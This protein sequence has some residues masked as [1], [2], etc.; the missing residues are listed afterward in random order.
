MGE[1][2]AVGV[3]ALLGVAVARAAHRAWR[4]GEGRSDTIATLRAIRW[5]HVLVPIPLLALLIGCVALLLTLPIPGMWVGWWMLLDGEGNAVLG[6]TSNSGPAWTLMAWVLPVLV[7]V[8]SPI[9]AR[10]EEEY[11][12]AGAE[13]WTWGRR[14][15]KCLRFGLLHMVAGVPLAAALAISL[16][17]AYYMAVYLLVFRQR[18]CR[19]VVERAGVY[20]M[21]TT[22]GGG[23]Y[24]E[25]CRAAVTSAAAAHTA[26][27]WTI[28]AIVVAAWAL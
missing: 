17:G 8:A 14:A 21:I 20:E 2:L 16:V 12:R 9:L 1:V 13:T 19:V 28:L 23:G 27:N 26:F 11:F 10:D 24:K 18:G 4:H 7:A 15:S 22:A 3:I 25:T 5:W 6:Q